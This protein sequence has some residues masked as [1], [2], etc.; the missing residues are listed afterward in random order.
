MIVLAALLGGCGSSRSGREGMLRAG[1]EALKG[2]YGAANN[3]D[4]QDACGRLTRGGIERIVHVRTRAACVRTISGFRKGAFAAG[5][6]ELVDVE[7]VEAAADGVDVEAEVKGR[8][9]GTYHL[10]RRGGKLLIDSFD[11]EEK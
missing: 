9:G 1:E 5:E 2:F 10:I 11:P 6:G 4:G 7:H 8:S 3:A